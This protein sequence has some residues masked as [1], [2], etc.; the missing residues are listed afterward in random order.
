MTITLDRPTQPTRPV[1][2]FPGAIGGVLTSP[3]AKLSTDREFGNAASGPDIGPQ[4]QNTAAINP[5]FVKRREEVRN[6]ELIRRVRRFLPLGGVLLVVAL[7]LLMLSSPWCSVR[8]V[9]VIGANAAVNA[10]IRST[11]G[12]VRG[13]PLVSVSAKKL[14]SRIGS[15]QNVARV[16]VT[17]RWPDGLV[18]KVVARTPFAVV[19]S[20]G[21]AVTVDATGFAM[22]SAQSPQASDEKSTE[23]SREENIAA[24]SLPRI[25]VTERTTAE[26]TETGPVS[27]K[28]K[29][30]LV[31]QAEAISILGYLDADTRASLS[32][33]TNFGDEFVLRFGKARILFGRKDDLEAKARIIRVLR[34]T[35]KL[36]APRTIDVTVPDAVIVS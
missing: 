13:R 28:E 31:R 8:T 33:V 7:V 14:A 20:D 27:E 11:L 30:A 36:N 16:D 34:E 9:E 5:L 12:D 4:R 6:T 15:R 21:D 22:T 17:K 18:V 2:T 25:T 1:S 23:E 24:A 26:P 29:P 3:I 35:Q 10:E 19:V 32:E